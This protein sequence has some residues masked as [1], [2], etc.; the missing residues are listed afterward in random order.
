M[1]V[2]NLRIDDFNALYF[3]SDAHL[4]APYG[5]SEEVKL[6]KLFA[7]GGGIAQPGNY[8]FIIGDLLDFW[9]EWRRSI[10]KRH[11][12]VLREIANWVD[13]GLSVHYLPGNH[14]FKLGGF[15]EKEIGMQTYEHTLDFSA[16]GKRF[17]LFHGDGLYKTDVWYRLM[18]KA[19]RFPLNQKLFLLV[20]PDLGQKLADVFSAGSRGSQDRKLNKD[21]ETDYFRYAEQ[22]IAAG[23]DFVIMGHTHKPIL[24][25]LGKGVYL[26][27]GDWHR[28]FTYGVFKEGNL[29][30][31]NFQ[32]TDE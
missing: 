24:K 26:N 25:K 23:F 11:F 2:E 15:L 6:S 7:F 8:L 21:L 28:R 32:S 9:F 31:E 5:A 16:L 4:G 18:K 30:L 12:R 20:H 17:H 27:T 13:R 3:I 22:K 10:P 14:D 19:L 29:S 1:N